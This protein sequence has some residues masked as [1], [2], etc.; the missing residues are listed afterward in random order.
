MTPEE[1][2]KAIKK[3]HLKY[4]LY[5]ECGHD[6]YK[7]EPEH[8]EGRTAIHIEDVG[9]TCA[10]PQWVCRECHLEGDEPGEYTDNYFWPCDTMK[11]VLEA[12]PDD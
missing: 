3:I 11:I 12:V 9:Y 1:K 10:E 8:H 7:D 6:E 5:P 2:L 4:G